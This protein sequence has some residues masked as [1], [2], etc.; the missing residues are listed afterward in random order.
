[1]FTDPTVVIDFKLNQHTCVVC[2]GLVMSYGN[3]DFDKQTNTHTRR[4]I[5]V[6]SE[7]GTCSVHQEQAI[8]KIMYGLSSPSCQLWDLAEY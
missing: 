4:D 6:V 8:L 5:F 1:M 2:G 3:D 7:R